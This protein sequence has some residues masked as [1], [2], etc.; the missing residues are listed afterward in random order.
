MAEALK[1]HRLVDHGPG[2][3]PGYGR[4]LRI[5]L[6]SPGD[7]PKERK[8]AL[9]VI[10]Q[11]QYESHLRGKVFLD[12]VAWDDPSGGGVMTATKTPQ[13]C[14]EK[15]L[16]RPA[17]CDIVVAIFWAR[18]GTPLPNP[19]YTKANGEPYWS[20]AE[21]EYEDAMESALRHD[22][23][24]VVVYRRLEEPEL[25]LGA[26][27]FEEQ[28][29]QH[30]RVAKFFDR[31]RDPKTGA[32]LAAWSGYRKPADFRRLFTKNLQTLVEGLL[33]A[34]TISC[35]LSTEHPL[36]LWPRSPFPGLRAF[37][38]DHEPIFFGR[39][40]EI[41]ELVDRT[42]RDRFVAV[43]GASGSGKSSLVWAGLIP[44]LKGN[45]IRSERAASTDW[46][47]LRFTP[48]AWATTLLWRSRSNWSAV[49]AASREKLPKN[50]PPSRRRS[51]N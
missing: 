32:N 30:R 17:E 11:L 25:K 49:S 15:G 27:D 5:F 51:P 3:P 50:W 38:D 29:E 44:A 8:I 9:R 40:R 7:V 16:T 20:G 46:M 14:I 34:P 18:M 45:S 39:D 23:P 26:P 48:A 19:P 31:F 41:D 10:E 24:Q 22:R 35:A 12:P 36:R 21:W 28:V 43:V 2:L 4:H 33:E 1:S 42:N 6:S 47:W 13:K 37:T